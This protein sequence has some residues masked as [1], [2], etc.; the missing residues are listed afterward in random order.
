MLIMEIVERSL[1]KDVAYQRLR[2]AIVEGTLEPGS[3]LRDSE[4]AH[5]LGLSRAPIRD[6]LARLTAN[7]LVESKPQSYTRVTEVVVKDVADAAAVVRAMHDLAVREAAGR[8]RSEHVAAMRS[9]NK[10]F[11]AAVRS[12]DVDAALVADD[13]LHGVLV[14]LCGNS[15]VAATIERYTPLIR[16]LERRLFSTALGQRSVRQHDALI[17]ACAAHDELAASE[18][19]LAIWSSLTAESDETDVSPTHHAFINTAAS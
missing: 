12:G 16:R 4:L 11:A 13:E 18:I 17:A 15:A 8:V 3:A 9:A 7:G 2:E 1:L 5:R 6:A 10:R 19:N 14:E